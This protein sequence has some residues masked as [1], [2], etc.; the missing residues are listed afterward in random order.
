MGFWSPVRP[1]QIMKT[2]IGAYTSGQVADREHFLGNDPKKVAWAMAANYLA[3][4]GQAQ[5]I[6]QLSANN[7][8]TAPELA[9]IYTV[10]DGGW[11]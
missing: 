4:C 7:P 6:G 3:A 8:L 2:Q 1:I 11:L 10:A 9:K 5:R